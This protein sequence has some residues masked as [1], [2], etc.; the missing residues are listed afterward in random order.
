MKAVVITRPGGPEVLAIH[1]VPRPVPGAGEAL[2]NVKASALNRADA[3][4]RQGKYPPPPGVRADVPGLEFAG[5][6]VDLGTGTSKWHVGQ[7]V[8]GITAGGAHAEY[9]VSHQDLLAEIPANL[10]WPEAGAI[11]EV[12]ITAYDALQQA[13]TRPGDRVLIHAAGSGVGLAAIQLCRAIGAI[14]YGSSR[15][16]DKLDRA[17]SYGLEHGFLLADAASLKT[18]PEDV[19][20][21]TV[22]EGFDVVLDLNGG[23]Y[24]APGLRAL[25]QKGRLVLIGAVAGSTAELDLRVILSQRLHV[26][27]TVLRARPLVE[28]A[29]VT[30]TFSREVVPLFSTGRLK[31]VIDS[32]FPLDDVQAAHRRLDSNQ[33]FGKIVLTLP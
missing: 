19:R 30:A 27:G 23:P 18:F 15:T 7:R 26:I 1:D 10:S 5:E 14:P 22:A 21:T 25:R 11:P 17:R 32:E 31:P 24:V 28:K 6:I 16:Q 3:L 20:K 33:S 13:A 9:L 29:A 8:F 2:I 4:Q 12:F